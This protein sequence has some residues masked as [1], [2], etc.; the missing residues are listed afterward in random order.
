MIHLVLT[1]RLKHVVQKTEHLMV[2]IN[3]L[4]LMQTRRERIVELL[5]SVDYPLTAEDICQELDIKQRSV[6]YEDIDHISKSLKNVGKSLLVRP[7]RCGKCDYV[8]KTKSSSKR[9]SKC[10]KCKSQWI[11]SPAF[12][13]RSRKR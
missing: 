12:L 13:I 1:L 2:G 4:I 11:I 7:A 6:V 8:F 10:P 9:P 3:E 5:E